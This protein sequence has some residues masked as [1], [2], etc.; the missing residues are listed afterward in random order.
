M[1]RILLLLMIG[2]Y[3]ATVSHGAAIT[4]AAPSIP[5]AFGPADAGFT[6]NPDHQAE[7]MKKKKKKKKKKSKKKKKKSKAS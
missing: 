3:T 5:Y 4:Q 1:K 6:D 7:E 2:A